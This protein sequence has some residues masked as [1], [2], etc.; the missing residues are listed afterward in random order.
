MANSSD[1]DASPMS[2]E[3]TKHLQTVIRH[4]KL[5]QDNCEKL[6]WSMIENGQPEQA[7]DL[8]KNA[9]KHDSSKL[10]GIEWLYL[11]EGSPHFDL[12]L[13][14]HVKTNPHHPEHWKSG[15]IE[16]PPIYIAEMVCDWKA[17]SD[18]FGTDL[19]SWIKESAY[20]R[21][22]IPPNGKV[23]KIVKKYLD[24]LLEKPFK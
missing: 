12:A 2:N 8:M 3:D 22:E 9:L 21:Y 1:D 15:I 16:M 13:E 23:A 7:I 17:R 20:K 5:V 11:R 18:E 6:A 10:D 24:L 14:Q 4:I 19:R